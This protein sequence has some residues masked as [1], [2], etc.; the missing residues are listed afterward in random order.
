MFHINSFFEF[1]K[2]IRQRHSFQLAQLIDHCQRRHEYFTIPSPLPPESNRRKSSG[3]NDDPVRDSLLNRR[4][5]PDLFQLA[6]ERIDNLVGETNTLQ[7][8]DFKKWNWHLILA[9]LKVNDI[10]EKRRG[11]TR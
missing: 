10:D 7:K 6:M 11:E 4:R 8:N 5:S 1:H 2:R 9:L 3:T